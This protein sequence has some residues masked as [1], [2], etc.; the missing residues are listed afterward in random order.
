M[1]FEREV[2]SL[3]FEKQTNFTSYRRQSGSYGVL[4]LIRTGRD[5]DAYSH[6]LLQS[7]KPEL[8]VSGW[9]RRKIQSGP[10]RPSQS[11]QQ[12]RSDPTSEPNLAAFPATARIDQQESQL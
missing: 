5:Q 6:E 2:L 7:G 8:T 9:I 10:S 1:R 12:R 3:Y 11:H 4:R